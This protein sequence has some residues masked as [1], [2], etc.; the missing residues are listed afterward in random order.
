MSRP[1]EAE[2][3]S[4]LSSVLL[5]KFAQENTGGL[6]LCCEAL[7]QMLFI[8]TLLTLCQRKFTTLKQWRSV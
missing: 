4:S 2:G 3:W 6:T 7:H 1:P 5:L 8:Y